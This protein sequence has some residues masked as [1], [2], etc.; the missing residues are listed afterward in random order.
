M[1]LAIG[2]AGYALWRLARA[3]LGHGQQQR[4]ST[5]DRVVALAS[6]VAYAILFVTAVQI[7]MG[8]GSSSGSPKEATGGVL[9]WTG[10]PLLIGTTGAVLIGVGGYQAFKGVTRKFLDDSRTDRMS[11]AVRRAFTALG[12]F[13]HVARAIIFALIGYGLIRAALDYDAR[14]AVGLDGA[15]RELSRASYGP[16]LLGVVALGLIG[17]A[18]YSAA[19]AR[20]RKI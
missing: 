18:A 5:G 15:L 9:G 12:V 19:D 11:D 3:A 2:L 13:G 4:D 17:F 6:G 14:Q 20:F 16:W 8:S 10:G 7:L 1:L